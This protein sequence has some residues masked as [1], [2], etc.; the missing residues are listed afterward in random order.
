MK[1]LWKRRRGFLNFVKK[2]GAGGIVRGKCFALKQG[3]DYLPE[4]ANGVLD[5]PKLEIY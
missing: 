4:P 3:G 5:T 2:V 1:N